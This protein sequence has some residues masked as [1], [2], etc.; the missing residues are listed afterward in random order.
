M[1]LVIGAVLQY[2]LCF[3]AA[4]GRAGAVIVVVGIFF[5]WKDVRGR[6]SRVE[7]A[8][9]ELL[10]QHYT[11]EFGEQRDRQMLNMEASI[12]AIGTLTWA[13]GDLLWPYYIALSL[14]VLLAFYLVDRAVDGRR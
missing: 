4:M 9:Q 5:T 13:F 10:D 1:L 8:V 7:N 2:G 14:A 12:I 3:E 11:P 6:F